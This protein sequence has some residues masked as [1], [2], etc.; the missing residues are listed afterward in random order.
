M[1]LIYIYAKII[2]IRFFS[3]IIFKISE[4]YKKV[5]RFSILKFFLAQDYLLKL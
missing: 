3:D 1:L 5:F 4:K 2:L